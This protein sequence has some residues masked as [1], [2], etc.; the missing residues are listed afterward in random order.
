MDLIAAELGMDPADVRRKNF[1]PP[2]DFPHETPTGIT[3]DSG[4]YADAL[5]RALAMSDYSHWRSRSR[6]Q[7]DSQPGTG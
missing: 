4:S 1:I 3:Y 6:Q 5:D 2:E 7:R